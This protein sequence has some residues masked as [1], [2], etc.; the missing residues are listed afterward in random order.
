MACRHVFLTDVVL[1]EFIRKAPVYYL[2]EVFQLILKDT[3]FQ[4]YQQL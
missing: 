1:T 2:S 3:M 4:F